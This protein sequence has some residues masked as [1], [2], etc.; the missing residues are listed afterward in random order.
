MW[1]EW[2]RG[3]GECKSVS[4]LR[5]TYTSWQHH[6]DYR[7]SHDHVTYGLN[8]KKYNNN[9]KDNLTEQKVVLKVQRKN[10]LRF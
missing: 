3:G 2:Q 6:I 7:T 10:Q 4:S 5:T 9:N 1:G 8:E